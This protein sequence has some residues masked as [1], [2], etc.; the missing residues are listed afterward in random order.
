MVFNACVLWSSCVY[1]LPQFASP[2]V[3]LSCQELSVQCKQHHVQP[4]HLP[5]FVIHTFH[6]QHVTVQHLS[7]QHFW[8]P[9]FKFSIQVFFKGIVFSGASMGQVDVVVF[10]VLDSTNDVAA[11]FK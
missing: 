9:S 10:P 5:S 11:D 2:T 1:S 6:S 3:S 7:A 4:L 8:I